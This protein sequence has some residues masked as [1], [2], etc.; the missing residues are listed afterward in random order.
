MVTRHEARRMSAACGLLAG[1]LAVRFPNRK[2]LWDGPAC[3]PL[4]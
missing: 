3:G 4:N 1:S 2:L